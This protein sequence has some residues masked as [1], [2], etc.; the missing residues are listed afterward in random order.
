MKQEIYYREKQVLATFAPV[1]RAT[2]WRW[3]K[4]GR[5][6]QPVSLGDRITVWRGSELE[7]WRRGKWKAPA[8]S[9][10]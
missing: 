10:G 8:G 5:A 7:R 2:W 3:V 6:P 4:A 1:S 9:G